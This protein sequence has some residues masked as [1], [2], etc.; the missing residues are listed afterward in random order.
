MKNAER[1]EKPL[2]VEVIPIR[3]RPAVVA[4]LQADVTALEKDVADKQKV[5]DKLKNDVT[6][7]Q[8][9]AADLDV[10]IENLEAVIVP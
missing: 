3:V 5:I 7:Q 1:T 2:N 4:K 6:T 10:R 8:Q 9:V